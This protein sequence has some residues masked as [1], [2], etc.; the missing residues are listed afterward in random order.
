MDIKIITQRDLNFIRLKDRNQKNRIINKKHHNLVPKLFLLK[1]SFY[2]NDFDKVVII[3]DEDLQYAYQQSQAHNKKSIKLYVYYKLSQPKIIQQDP[4]IKISIQQ[5]QK[6][7]INQ[8]FKQISSQS[9]TNSKELQNNDCSY[10]N[11]YTLIP[12][13]KPTREEKLKQ[14]IDSFIDQVLKDEYQI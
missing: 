6:D 10:Q 1:L 13:P 4:S 2:D 3:S 9:L 11:R 8:S 14:A 7:W 12:E 5:P